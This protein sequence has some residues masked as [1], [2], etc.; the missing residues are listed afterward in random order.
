M[1]EG[2]EG[3]SSPDVWVWPAP[4]GHKVVCWREE[5]K[6]TSYEARWDALA[7]KQV[8]KQGAEAAKGLGCWAGP[9]QTPASLT[10]VS[11]ALF[12]LADE[13]CSPCLSPEAS[14]GMPEIGTKNN[15]ELNNVQCIYWVWRIT[16]SH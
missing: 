4:R 11:G 2:G 10:H 15:S 6:L 3:A 8:Q 1:V 12:V 14:A 16:V 7:F 13:L 5:G 9:L